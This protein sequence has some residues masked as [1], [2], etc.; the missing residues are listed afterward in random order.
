MMTIPYWSPLLYAFSKYPQALLFDTDIYC[1][2][3]ASSGSSYIFFCCDSTSFFVVSNNCCHIQIL[4]E[5][6]LH[7]YRSK[8]QGFLIQCCL[9]RFDTEL[10]SQAA[11]AIPSGALL[12]AL[13]QHCYLISN[14]RLSVWSCCITFYIKLFA[15]VSIPCFAACQYVD[16]K[17]FTTTSKLYPPLFPEF[18]ASIIRCLSVVS[19]AATSC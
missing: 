15:A 2:K 16:W 9:Q 5:H 18:L 13:V 14:I 19:S 7:L 4:P 10:W 12:I 6:L 8:L 3:V 1:R 17:L 11:S